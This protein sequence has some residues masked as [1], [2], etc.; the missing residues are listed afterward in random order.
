ME[1]GKQDESQ[2]D[3]R[4]VEKPQ[5]PLSIR[6]LGVGM[7]TL[8]ILFLL[9]GPVLFP[10]FESSY[11]LITLFKYYLFWGGLIHVV[12]GYGLL[13]LDSVCRW[14]ALLNITV[15]FMATI[16]FAYISTMN[17]DLPAMLRWEDIL[18]HTDSPYLLSISIL[19]LAMFV[20]CFLI[21]THPAVV[22]R[23]EEA[24]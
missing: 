12:T 23:F 15:N 3:V 19:A 17:N 6:L 5:C 21:L 10:S 7:I 22:R 2:Y 24:P 16:S 1:S 8:G 14:L 18:H 4:F 20:V 13:Q 9:L 11:Y